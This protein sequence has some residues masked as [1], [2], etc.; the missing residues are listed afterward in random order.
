LGEEGSSLFEDVGM[1]LGEMVVDPQATQKWI[2][3]RKHGIAPWGSM[4]SLNS[5]SCLEETE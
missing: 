2:I 5:L 3:F 1:D 4:Y